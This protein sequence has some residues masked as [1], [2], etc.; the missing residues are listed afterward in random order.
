MSQ[1]SYSTI[2]SLQPRR[3]SVNGR[4]GLNPGT[5][6]ARDEHMRSDSHFWEGIWMKRKRWTERQI[7][8]ALRQ[9]EQGTA[10]SEICQKMGVA[11]AT[12]YRGASARPV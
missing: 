5:W 7:A 12:F 6:S 2:V 4:N 1:W 11:E 10:V 9:A 3:R 8:F